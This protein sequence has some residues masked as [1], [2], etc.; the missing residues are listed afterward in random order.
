[1]GY[2]LKKRPVAAAETKLQLLV[3]S[4]EAPNKFYKNDLIE[5]RLS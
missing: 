1:M 5:R 3:T 4:S 2:D